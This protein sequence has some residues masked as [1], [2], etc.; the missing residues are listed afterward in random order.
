[1]RI[2]IAE[3]DATCRATLAAVL[4]KGGHE[5]KE[6]A[7]GL[8][9]WEEMQKP[10]APRLVILDWIMPGIDGLEVLRRVRALRPP[11]PPYLIL[12][13]SRAGKD[14]VIT[15]L[16]AGAD[17]YVS[18]PYDAGELHARIDAGR[19]MLGLQDALA[20]K[21]EELHQA[22]NQIKALRGIVPICACCKKIRDDQGYWNQ[23]EVYIRNHTGA[24]LSHGF[25]P[26]CMAK[27]YPEVSCA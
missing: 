20:A 26:A 13:T 17:D 7:G 19:R 15:G 16:E 25:C 21:V 23:V 4:K 18:K 22:L 1:M 6:T 9:A 14:D 24:E 8:E 10:D 11:R 3:D 12:L 5:V 2:L 27:Y